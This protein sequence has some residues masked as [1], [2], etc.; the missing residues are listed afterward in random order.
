ME[1]LGET[2]EEENKKIIHTYPL[3]K[4]CDM[5][6]EMKSEAIEV[7]ITACEKFGNDYYAA[8]KTIKQTMDKKYGPQWNTI[9]G[10]AYGIQMTHQTKTLLYMFFGG[11]LAICTW[12]I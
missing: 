7:I 3:V 10:E 6:E 12:K 11:N 5:T 8:A 4:I 1:D 9:V 2:K